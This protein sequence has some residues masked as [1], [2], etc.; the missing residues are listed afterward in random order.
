MRKFIIGAVAV[1]GLAL[2]TPALSQV[3]LGA[4]PGG[5]GIGV[6]PGPGYHNG[7]EGRRYRSYGR[8][9]A[10][11]RTRLIETRYGVRKVRRCY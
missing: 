8:G 11:C 2:A 4:G 5:V 6:G 7:Y 10:Q 1:A 9:Y 3:Y